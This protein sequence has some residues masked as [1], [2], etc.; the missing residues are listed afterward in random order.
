MKGTV[1]RHSGNMTLVK[2]SGTNETDTFV[3]TLPRI[4]LSLKE[5]AP[6]ESI[7]QSEMRGIMTACYSNLSPRATRGRATSS[8]DVSIAHNVYRD[9][10]NN[11]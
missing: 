3:L 9:T 7:C 11:D 5:I 10:I 6:Y 4:C 8:N 2:F 1:Q